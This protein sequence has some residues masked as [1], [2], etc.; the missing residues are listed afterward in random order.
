MLTADGAL[1]V[2]RETGQAAARRVPHAAGVVGALGEQRVQEPA[3]LVLLVALRG[4]DVL[5]GA[6]VRPREE[7]LQ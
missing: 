3:H 6:A 1:L 4:Q 7:Q 2:L 5:G